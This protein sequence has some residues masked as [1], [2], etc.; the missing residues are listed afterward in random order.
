MRREKCLKINHRR[1]SL[2]PSAP[3]LLGGVPEVGP[4]PERRLVAGS[5]VQNLLPDSVT[6]QRELLMTLNPGF[7][8]ASYHLILNV[9]L[10]IKRWISIV[11]IFFILS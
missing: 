4:G 1:P 10:T 2:Q 5:P 8:D 3:L 7:Q 11:K 9:L 6:R